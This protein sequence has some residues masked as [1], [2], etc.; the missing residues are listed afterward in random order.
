MAG[1]PR[2]LE[3]RREKLDTYERDLVAWKGLLSRAVPGTL[4]A[5]FS[6][7]F[8]VDLTWRLAKEDILKSNAV[9]PLESLWCTQGSLRC[10]LVVYSQG[11][12]VRASVTPSSS[13]G[14]DVEHLDMN[15]SFSCTEPEGTER[16]VLQ[17]STLTV[18]EQDWVSGC[19]LIELNHCPR[20][21]QFELKVHAYVALLTPAKT[22]Q[23]AEINELDNNQRSRADWVLMKPDRSHRLKREGLAARSL[24]LSLPRRHAWGGR[25][26]EKRERVQ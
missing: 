25:E 19:L 8:R 22:F 11:Y 18:D 9:Y 26:G 13:P 6:S 21:V 12:F 16:R 4:L 7:D 5:S 17:T 1:S 14:L 10:R 24:E 15:Y 23:H 3:A 2:R 20:E